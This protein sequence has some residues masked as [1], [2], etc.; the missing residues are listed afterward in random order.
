M[1]T[2]IACVPT[3]VP[4]RAAAASA[5]TR[6]RTLVG[7][8]LI[9]HGDNFATG[10]MVMQTG[11][12]TASGY[13]RLTL[14][15]SQH[16]RTLALA[17]ASV[18]VQGTL[19]SNSFT[20]SQVSPLPDPRAVAR[21]AGWV[22]SPQVMRIAVVLM[23]LPGSS[24]APASKAAVKRST[25]GAKRS[26]ADWYSQTSGKHVVVTGT[27]F[28]IYTGVRSCDLGV[29]L[30]AAAAAAAKGGYVASDFDHLVVVEPEQSCGFS[31]IGWVGQNGVFLN[32]D[33][34]PGVMEHELGHNLGLWHAGAYSC[35][36]SAVSA[37]CLTEYGD[38]TDVM[39]SPYLDH[40]YNAEHKRRIGWIPATEVRTVV[41]GTQ[42]ITL[43]ASEDP[44]VLGAIELI[45]LRAADGTI[46]SIDK[47]AS[48]GYDAG[49]SGVWIRRLS[50]TNTVD[51][52]LVRNSAYTPGTTFTDAVHRVT[53]KT[54]SDS[55]PAAKVR[56]CVGA[57]R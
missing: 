28:G 25:F 19:S 2:V 56:V 20:V 52:A 31:G 32:G 9:A 48:I 36:A 26:V 1:L 3:T 29:Q 42:T 53:I 7:R 47:R 14:P 15:V 50:A 6:S 30:S 24:T 57:C 18:R 51:T 17:G 13:V 49:L 10:A 4:A 45:H 46:Y 11:L 37:A 44:V 38:P 8:L 16:A 23:R 39:G 40:G 5:L 33:A 34:T 12:R 21:P 55:G 54:L 43:T 27:V 35:P 22:R 41:A